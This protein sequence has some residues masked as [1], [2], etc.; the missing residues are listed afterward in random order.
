MPGAEPGLVAVAPTGLYVQE[1]S[2]GTYAAAQQAFVALS[3]RA[4]TMMSGIQPIYHQVDVDGQ[5]RYRLYLTGWLDETAART[6]APYL[7]R[8]QSTWLVKNG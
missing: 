7:G 8:T 6:A 1:G 2:Y 4:P 5:T 3:A